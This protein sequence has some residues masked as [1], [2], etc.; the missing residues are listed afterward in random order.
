MTERT[1]SMESI[2]AAMGPA[3]AQAKAQHGG[4]PDRALN[5]FCQAVIDGL[6]ALPEPEGVYRM[7][8]SGFD[9]N[10][11]QFYSQTEDSDRIYDVIEYVDDDFT[12]SND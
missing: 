6:K 8:E 12:S 1:Y 3:F 7:I 2:T 11:G 10:V 5:I 9:P 4:N